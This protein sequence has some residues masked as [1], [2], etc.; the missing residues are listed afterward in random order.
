MEHENPTNYLEMLS[1]IEELSQM[2]TDIL[3][4]G[5]IDEYLRILKKSALGEKVKTE[6]E[7]SIML[8]L[9]GVLQNE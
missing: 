5:Y 2:L 7:K 3:S 6:T 9:P 1:K 8:G 4:S